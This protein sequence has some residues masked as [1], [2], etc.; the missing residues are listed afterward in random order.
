MDAKAELQCMMWKEVSFWS[1]QGEAMQAIQEGV[2]PVVGVMP[3][4]AG[5]S[6]L[7]MMPAFVQVGGVTIVVVPLKALRADMV[8]RCGGVSTR[9]TVWEQDSAVDGASIVLVT[10]EKAASP[11]F[12]TFISRIQQTERLDRIVLDECHVILN[13]RW[14]FK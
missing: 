5:K 6:V 11:A 8:V 13:E 9:R 10:P 2:S 3:T 1:V 12:G 4:V 7:F 14:N